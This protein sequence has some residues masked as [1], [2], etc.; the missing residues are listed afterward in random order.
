MADRHKDLASDV[1]LAQTKHFSVKIASRPHVTAEEG[2]HLF[3]EVNDPSIED[4]TQLEG[5]AAIELMWLTIVAGEAMGQAL[6][7]NGLDIYRINY[8]DNGNWSFLRGERP[9]LHVH[10]YARIR[11]ETYQTFGQALV[12]PDPH[13]AV[14]DELKPIDID[15]GLAIARKMD[16]LAKAEKNAW[17]TPSD[18][19]F[20]LSTHVL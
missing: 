8:Q 7:Q 15:T 20:P 13:D 4:R 16:E 14:Y 19:T 2:G 17:F 3:I 18:L 1:V 12:F 6:R 9:R 5:E 11:D 10:L